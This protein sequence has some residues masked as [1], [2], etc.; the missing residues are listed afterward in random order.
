MGSPYFLF[1]QHF[2]PDFSYGP[3]FDLPCID[4]FASNFRITPLQADGANGYTRD[5]PPGTTFV[6]ASLGYNATGS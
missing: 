5:A 2:S 6:V 1:E 3:R 4:R